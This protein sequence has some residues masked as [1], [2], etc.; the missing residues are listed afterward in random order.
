[1]ELLNHPNCLKLYSTIET[2]NNIFIL[3]DL[4]PD[5][6]LFGHIVRKSFLEEH[7]ASLI[8]EQLIDALLYVHT[9]GIIHRDIKPEN[10]MI[11]LDRRTDLVQTVKVIDFGLAIL[12]GPNQNTTDVCGT[13]SYVSPE[14]LVGKGCS[15]ASDAFSLGAVMHFMLRGFPPFEGTT[16]SDVFKKTVREDVSLDSKH[17]ENVSV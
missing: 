17:W 4:V 7:E 10:I 12:M 16:H 9:V 14:V 3:T 13:I 5:G 15:K 11:Q 6:D 8:M 1:V 2:D